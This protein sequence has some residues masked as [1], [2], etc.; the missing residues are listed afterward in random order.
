M[1]AN[2]IQWEGQALLSSLFFGMI[3]AWEYD[4]IRIFRRIVKHRRVW[5]MSIEDILY[6]INASITVFCMTYEVNDGIV[7]GFLVAGFIVGAVIY[8]HSFGKYFVKYVS[9]L[10]NFILKP[11]KKMLY[12]I[13]MVLWKTFVK[14]K[15]LAEVKGKGKGNEV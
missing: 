9:K 1:I 12:L 8:R 10:I 2:L 13:R 5:V 6:W 11:L 4:C 15:K 3:L 14:L 7:R